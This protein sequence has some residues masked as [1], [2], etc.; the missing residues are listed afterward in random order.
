MSDEFEDLLKRWLRERGGTDRSAIQALAGNVAALPPRNQRRP[1]Q[2]ATAAAVLVALGLGV[3]FLVPRSGGVT[4]PAGPTGGTS[5]SAASPVPPD[6]A[7]FA[8]DPRLA[9][10]VASVLTALDVFEMAHARDYRLYLPAMLLAPELDVDDPAFVVVYRGQNPVPYTGPS[11]VGPRPSLAPGHHDM[12][13][14]VGPDAVTAVLNNYDDVD[15]TGLTVDVVSAE[16]SGPTGTATPTEPPSGQTTPEPGPSWAGD[17]RAVLQCDGPPS[18][19]SVE[20]TVPGAGAADARRALDAYLARIGQFRLAF[21]TDSFVE[22]DSVGSWTL[23]GYRVGERTRAAVVLERSP[24]GGWS[25]AKIAAC[26]PS[27]FDPTTP[28]GI[29]ITIWTGPGGSAVPTTMIREVTDCY[30]GTQLTVN[31]RL[32]VWDNGHAGAYDPAT[33]E[34]TFQT[35]PLIPSAAL[36]TAFSEGARQLYFAPDG[37]AAYVETPTG[38]QRWPHVIGDEIVRVDCN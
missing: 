18:E 37:S 22:I 11:G 9:R 29:P 4:A 31:G 26:D 15:T 21:P 3:F 16:P 14:L 7:A 13:V 8:G 38:V 5:P 34:G 28:L 17:A 25:V 35:T 30:G 27:E 23:Y 19:L 36:L 2:L 10:C 1:S 20:G 6:P 24:A 33:L 12:C 32:Y